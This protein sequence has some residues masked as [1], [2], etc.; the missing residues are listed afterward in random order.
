MPGGMLSAAANSR[1]RDLRIYHTEKI[2]S[3][4][5][6]ET[7][8]RFARSSAEARHGG[9]TNR[10]YYGGSAFARSAM[11]INARS[12]FKADCLQCS[13]SSKSLR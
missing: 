6:G 1:R 3:D 2:E 10:S 8:I 11:A 5:R 4:I 12:L 7:S 13:Y 9:E